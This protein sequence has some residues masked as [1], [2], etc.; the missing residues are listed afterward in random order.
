MNKPTNHHHHDPKVIETMILKA[1][2]HMV[3]G[4]LNI[5]DVVAVR[6]FL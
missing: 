5:G 4:L 6:H 2:R 3:K 1:S